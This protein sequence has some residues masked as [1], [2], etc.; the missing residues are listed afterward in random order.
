MMGAVNASTRWME[1]L[2]VSIWAYEVSGSPLV[3]SIMLFA[4]TLPM[5]LFG[6]A[7]GV[8]VERFDRRKLLI[9]SFSSLATVSCVLAILSLT[10][11]LAVWHAAVGA[12][13][14]GTLFACDFPLRRTLLGESAG[15]SG[16]NV[17]MALE[18]VT[19]NTT[20][21]VGPL[22]AGAFMEYADIY[23]SYMVTT[24][25]CTGAALLAVGLS[26]KPPVERPAEGAGSRSFLTELKEGMAYA[27]ARP[28]IMGALSVTALA[29]TFGFPYT[30]LIPVIGKEV[31]DLGPLMVG[32]LASA[33]GVGS[34]TTALWLT[35]KPTRHVGTTYFLGTLFMMAPVILF[36]MS[37]W[38]A[39]SFFL[40]LL[41]GYGQA[42]FT[43]TQGAIVFALAEPHM[44][45]RVMG[46]I[47]T[48]IGTMPA[49]VLFMGAVASVA[50]A[51]WAV[52]ISSAMGVAGLGVV[53]LAFRDL[54]RH[55]PR[56][57]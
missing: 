1:I 10:G 24:C 47:A 13:I 19:L 48:C 37:P 8:L 51:S 53:R 30:A 3:V 17:A 7:A 21:L 46:L 4:R 18:S 27:R 45:G 34:L 5:V 52:G 41:S 22:V 43:S 32:V 36:A 54:L 9:A 31:L 28:A 20:R 29:N 39:L 49:G 15:P 55:P 56:P 50:S 14:S 2:A 25:L 35:M 23:G 38:F 33:T 26:P 44:R 40:L 11:N 12:F 16:V 57:T 6:A 42:S